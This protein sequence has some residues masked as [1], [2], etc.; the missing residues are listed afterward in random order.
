MADRPVFN[1][2]ATSNDGRDIT[3][4]WMGPLMRTQDSVLLNRGGGN[5]LAY[6]ELLRD[7]QVASCLQQRRLSVVAADWEVQPGKRRFMAPTAQDQKAVEFVQEML[8]TGL[9]FDDLTAK[10][11]Y[12]VMFGYAVGEVMWAKDGNYIVFDD[13]RQGIKA[14]KARRFDFDTEGRLRLLTV[15]NNWEGELLPDRKFWL[16]SFGGDND[17]HP[18]GLGLGH[19]LYWPVYFKRGGMQ[20]WLRFLNKF[21][22]PSRIAKYP[23]GTSTEDQDKL[24][25]A[26]EALESD[27]AVRI[28][29]GLTIELLEATRGGTADYS[30]LVQTMDEAIAKIIL[31]QHFSTEG[32]GGQYKGDNLMSVRDEVIKSDADQLCLSMTRQPITWLIEYNRSVLGEDVAIPQVWRRLP[33]GEDLAQTADTWTKLYQIGFEPSEQ[34]VQERFGEG[35]RRKSEPVA[36]TL[37]PAPVPGQPAPTQSPPVEFKEPEDDRDT[38]D[39]YAEQL[40]SALGP[41][42]EGWLGRI[43]EE[44]EGSGDLQEFA[45]RLYGLYPEL[46]AAEFSEIMS[47]A[48]IASELA[49]R[50]ESQEQLPGVLYV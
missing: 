23:P 47:Q 3:Q 15:Q 46:P 48:L 38:V 49:G 28:P 37:K 4:P 41:V 25:R 16:F 30:Q 32:S 36:A 27:S 31:S 13:L 33:E 24:L 5:L 18:G 1:E 39:F 6:E 45:D 12:G 50:Y 42:L 11:H 40:R 10:M 17:D 44:L 26:A 22:V 35:W 2:I 14:K 21:G 7:D 20:A 29:E 19:Y 34:D 9:E 8:L 43:A